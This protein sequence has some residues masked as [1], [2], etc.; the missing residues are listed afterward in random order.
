MDK[1][2]KLNR[3]QKAL[4][5]KLGKLFDELKKENVGI[6]LRQDDVIHAHLS[7]MTIVLI[8]RKAEIHFFLFKFVFKS[9]Q[10]FTL[11]N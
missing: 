8:C 10:L 9:C 2:L 1:R 5:N 4:V 7:D 6:V 11:K 3:K